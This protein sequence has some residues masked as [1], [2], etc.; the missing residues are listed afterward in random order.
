M[1]TLPEVNGRAPEIPPFPYSWNPILRGVERIWRRFKDPEK[2]HQQSY[3]QGLGDGA[4]L[5]ARTLEH[6]I[7]NENSPV[8]GYAELLGGRPSVQADTVATEFL[9]LITEGSKGISRFINLATNIRRVLI[10]THQTVVPII[11]LGENREVKTQ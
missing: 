9:S 2:I 11:D 3:L 7:N 10:S 5:M 6:H 8:T 4:L 1:S